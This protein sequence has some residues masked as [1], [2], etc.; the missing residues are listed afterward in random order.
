M[1][2]DMID[3]DQNPD[4]EISPSNENLP[5]SMDSPEWIPDENMEC[6]DLDDKQPSNSKPL[7]KRKRKKDPSKY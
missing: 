3:N 1:A 5:S 7:A 4:D 2:T 6:E